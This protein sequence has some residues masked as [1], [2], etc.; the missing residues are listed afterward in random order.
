[1]KRLLFCL[2]AL[3]LA[4]PAFAGSYVLTTTS[5]Q[6][7]R[8]E[9]WRVRLNRNTCQYYGLAA[10]CT[11]VNARKAFC[12]RAGFGAITSCDGANQV[13]VYSDVQ[14]MLNDQ[15]TSLFDQWKTQLDTE[16][17]AA[18]DAAKAA[19]TVAQKNAACA[20]LGLPNGCL[21]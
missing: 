11:Q 1:M 16:G 8:F 15:V 2:L 7:A 9:R 3:T 18:F 6:D 10:D 17:Q 14:T 19:A 21:P 12:T 4:L 13:D 5:N 20:A